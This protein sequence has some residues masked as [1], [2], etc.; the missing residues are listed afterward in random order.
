[1]KQLVHAVSFVVL[2]A[3]TPSYVGEVEWKGLYMLILFV[4][5][6]WFLQVDEQCWV[7]AWQHVCIKRNIGRAEYRAWCVNHLAPRSCSWST[8]SFLSPVSWASWSPS[9]SSQSSRA[10]A[11]TGAPLCDRLDR[12]ILSPEEDQ[13]GTCRWLGAE[14]ELRRPRVPRYGSARR[15]IGSKV[16]R[17]R[18]GLT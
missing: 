18:K 11:E 8:R 14:L 9:F 16:S 12:S 6:S 4:H 3:S 1:M 15:K 7:F 2:P 13:V 5:S 17:A 10:T